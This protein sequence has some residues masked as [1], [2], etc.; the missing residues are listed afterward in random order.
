[1][2]EIF[3][4]ENFVIKKNESS[5]AL[6]YLIRHWKFVSILNKLVIVQLWVRFLFKKKTHQ[7]KQH[8][9][10]TQLF[11]IIK[12]V[13]FFVE[14]E[15]DSLFINEWEVMFHIIGC[16]DDLLLILSGTSPLAK[17]KLTNNWSGNTIRMEN[18]Y[19]WKHYH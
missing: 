5:P 4:S 11:D 9:E 18:L 17:N 14:T 16:Q 8:A 3:L 12:H 2:W 1:M 19:F 6:I 10:C 7:C 13:L 15:L